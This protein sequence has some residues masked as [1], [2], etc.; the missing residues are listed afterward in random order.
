[1][2]IFDIASLERLKNI[3]ISSENTTIKSKEIHTIETF[4]NTYRLQKNHPPFK[5]ERNL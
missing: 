5:S 3:K 2:F 1:M 4:I